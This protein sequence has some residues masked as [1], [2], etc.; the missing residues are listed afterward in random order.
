[1]ALLSL[2][3]DRLLYIVIY[4]QIVNGKLEFIAASQTYDAW[5]DADI[6]AKAT[7]LTNKCRAWVAG[8]GR[9]AR[10]ELAK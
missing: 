7:A 9:P 4:E 2:K 1:M 10:I 5:E 3:E 6:A 8:I